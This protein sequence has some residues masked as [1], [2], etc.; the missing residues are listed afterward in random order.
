MQIIITSDSPL[1][2][3]R[4]VATLRIEE[5]GRY[6]LSAINESGESIKNRAYLLDIEAKFEKS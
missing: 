2:M 6:R 1:F 3:M 4:R 5:Y